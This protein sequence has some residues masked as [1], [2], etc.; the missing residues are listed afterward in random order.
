MTRRGVRCLPGNFE[1]EGIAV[2][3][4]APVGR[5]VCNQVKV[6]KIPDEVGEGDVRFQ[7]GEGGAETMMDAVAE[8]N[9]KIGGAAEV[10][11]V[12]RGELGWI[13]V[14][15]AEERHDALAFPNCLAAKI[16]IVG[17]H[18]GLVLDRTVEAK[19]FLDGGTG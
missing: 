6:G 17:R 14:G 3:G 11:A 13:P 8:G 10:E 19:E 7:P 16:Q 2:G 15:R 1:T 12:G 18:P 9:V 5:I 4:V